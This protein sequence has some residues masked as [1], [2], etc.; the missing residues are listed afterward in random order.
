MTVEQAKNINK[1]YINYNDSIVK[2]NDSLNTKIY[3]YERL[4]KTIFEKTDSIY[5]WKIRY[6]AARDLTNYR[7]KDHEKIDQAQEIGRYI[8]ILIIILQFIKIH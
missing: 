2:L 6:E 4:N 3:D 8:L 5:L 7:T 1:L